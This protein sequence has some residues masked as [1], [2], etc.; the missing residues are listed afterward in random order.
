MSIEQAAE[1]AV[2]VWDS[3]QINGMDLAALMV[4]IAGRESG[5]NP[6]ADGDSIYTYPQLSGLPNCHGYT[7]F[8]LW[9]INSS[10]SAYLKQ[11][12]GS[13]DPCV[14]AQW[15]HDPL[16]NARAADVI[17]R[18]QGLSAWTTYV[19]GAYRAFL[20]QASRAVQSVRSA[21]PAPSTPSPPTLAYTPAYNP[22]SVWAV[23]AG[24]VL[25]IGGVGGIV[26]TTR[27]YGARMWI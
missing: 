21:Y 13:S 24:T 3:R 15:L 16:N 8:G 20:D 11:A 9:Q 5:W 10:H 26:W 4:A 19:T 17:L 25:V 18:Y 12:T 2:A 14:W 6:S 23:A 1:A 7:S 22:V 27:R